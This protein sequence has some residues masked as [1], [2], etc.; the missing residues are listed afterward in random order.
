MSTDEIRNRDREVIA[1]LGNPDEDPLLRAEMD[2]RE[3]LNHIEQMDKAKP[4]YLLSLDAK[5]LR[6]LADYLE[7]LE[8]AEQASIALEGKQGIFASAIYN[9]YTYE[10]RVLRDDYLLPVIL[11]GHL[12][13]QIGMGDR[14]EIGMYVLSKKFEE[15]K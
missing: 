13:G 4:D 9:E 6:A 11:E 2:R 10:D 3:L 15:D 8:A 14:G 5:D 12:I 1:R 7:A